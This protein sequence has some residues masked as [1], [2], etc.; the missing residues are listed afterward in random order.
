MLHQIDYAL[1]LIPLNS[2]ALKRCG[3][4]TGSASPWARILLV[5]VRRDRKTKVSTDSASLCLHISEDVSVKRMVVKVVCILRQ[6]I[7]NILV[8]HA[9]CDAPLGHV[10]KSQVATSWG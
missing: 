3:E 9:I 6:E 4:A 1:I 5:V 10:C 7:L 8:N 2:L